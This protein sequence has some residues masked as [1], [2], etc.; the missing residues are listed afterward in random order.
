MY[1]FIRKLSKIIHK[2]VHKLKLFVACPATENKNVWPFVG[3]RI[4][5][6]IIPNEEMSFLGSGVEQGTLNILN[7]RWTIQISFFFFKNRHVATWGGGGGGG[8]WPKFAAYCPT[9]KL[10][11]LSIL[12]IIIFLSGQT[13][14]CCP[15][16]DCMLLTSL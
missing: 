1:D 16:T 2:C 7:W 13:N 11:W 12:E 6:K 10:F 4:Q 3:V 14:S 9:P 5:C 8:T 15:R